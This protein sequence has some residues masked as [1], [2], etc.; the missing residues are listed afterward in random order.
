VVEASFA[1]ALG[2]R[3]GGT[4]TYYGNRIEHRALM[5]DGRTPTPDD[6]PAAVELARRVGWGA[7]IVAA[8]ISLF[9]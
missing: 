6:I 2:I 3:L 4:N 8:G 9:R 5:G 1:G 7:A